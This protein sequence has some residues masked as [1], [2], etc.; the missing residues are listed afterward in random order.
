MRTASPRKL[1]ANSAPGAIFSRAC[2]DL[3]PRNF[4]PAN[5]FQRCHEAKRDYVAKNV[6]S[7]QNSPLPPTQTLRPPLFRLAAQ[8]I[9]IENFRQQ[10]GRTREAVA[11]MMPGAVGRYERRLVRPG[12]Q[13]LFAERRGE[14]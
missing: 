1:V 3:L 13:R 9:A 12:A 10:R 2:A 8:R 6:I 7:R 4:N 14:A 11:T 5:P